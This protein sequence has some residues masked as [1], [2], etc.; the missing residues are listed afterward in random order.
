MVKFKSITKNHNFLQNSILL[1]N[2][3]EQFSSESIPIS[4]VWDIENEKCYLV[5]GS[6]WYASYQVFWKIKNFVCFPKR[7]FHIHKWTNDKKA[8]CNIT[9]IAWTLGTTAASDFNCEAVLEAS[10]WHTGASS[11]GFKF[12][13]TGQWQPRSKGQRLHLLETALHR[14]CGCKGMIRCLPVLEWFLIE[15]WK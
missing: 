11:A 3:W 7:N 10:N 8:Q 1:A 2:T 13:D 4:S 14:P 6:W 9:F 5:T 12:S 15:C